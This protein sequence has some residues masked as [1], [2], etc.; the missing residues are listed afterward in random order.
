MDGN[1]D[2]DGA[3]IEAAV[4]ALHRSRRRRALARL[5]ERRGEHT[6]TGLPDGV[7]EL[8]DAVASAADEETALTVTEAAAVLG[9][10]QPRSSRLAAQAV[11]AGLVRRVADQHDGRR[12]LLAPTPQGRGVLA[13]IRDFRRRAVAEATADWPADDRAALARLLTRFVRDFDAV[14][15]RRDG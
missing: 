11:A 15:A 2:V 7:F 13:R 1:P 9:V 12:S 3:E 6:A 10:D 4:N 8:L 14:T 5:A